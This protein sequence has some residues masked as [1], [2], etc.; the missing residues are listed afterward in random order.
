MH[1][2]NLPQQDGFE[3]QLV[4]LVFGR[5]YFDTALRQ[6]TKDG[7]VVDLTAAEARLLVALAVT[8]NHA[9]SRDSLLVRARGRDYGAA[10]RSID[11][12]IRRLRQMIE[13]DPSTPRFIKTIRGSGYMLVAEVMT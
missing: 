1:L 12:R 3:D 11:V 4:D 8:P 13:D 7:E 6:L 9:V 5:C 10:G 2:H